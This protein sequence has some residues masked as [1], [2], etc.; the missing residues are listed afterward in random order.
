LNATAKDK[1]D[2][3]T[4]AKKRL[5]LRSSRLH[6]ARAK[7]GYWAKKNKKPKPDADK[8]LHVNGTPI[9]FQRLAAQGYVG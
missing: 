8:Q 1:S 2:G 7:S 3:E 4:N 6:A 5:G 9:F